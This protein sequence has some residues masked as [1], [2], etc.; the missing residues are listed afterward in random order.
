MAIL[1]SIS[2]NNI[3]NGRRFEL[4]MK[5]GVDNQEIRKFKK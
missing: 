2:V 1:L 4:L 3:K 5:G